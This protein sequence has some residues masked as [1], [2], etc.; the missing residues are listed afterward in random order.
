[1]VPATPTSTNFVVSNSDDSGPGSLREAIQLANATATASTITFDPGL[2]NQV[3]FLNSGELLITNPVRI[4]GLEGNQIIING[5]GE[6]RI[7]KIDSGGDNIDVL[8]ENLRIQEGGTDDDGGGIWNR[9]NLTLKNFEV[10]GNSATDD[11]GGIRNDGRLVVVDSVITG[12]RANGTSPTSGG[13]GILNTVGAS[14]TLINSTVSENTAPN[15]GG[16]RNDGETMIQNST[17]SGNNATAAAGGGG[18]IASSGNEVTIQNS[19][20]T[21]NRAAGVGAGISTAGNVMLTNS[22]VAANEDDKDVFRL[23]GGDFSSG[24]RNLIGNGD[25]SSF[26]DDSGDNIV[27]TS[28]GAIDPLLDSLNNNGGLTRTHALLD[29]SPAIDAGSSNQLPADSQDADGDSDTTEMIPFDQR[30][31]GFLRVFG[32]ALDIGA[33]EAVSEANEPPVAQSVMFSVVENSEEGTAVGGVSAFDREEAALNFAFADGNLDLDED[34]RSAFS[35]DASTGEITVNDVDDIDFDKLSEFDLQVKV[36]DSGDLSDTANVKVQVVEQ[37]FAQFDVE[38]SRNGVFVLGRGQLANLK[39]M[40]SEANIDSVGEVGFFLL[41]EDN[42]IDGLVA[43]DEGYELAALERSQV[44]FSTLANRPAG[45]S[46]ENIQRILPVD[47]ETRLG[48]LAVNDGTIEEA[49][50]D[51]QASGGNAFSILFSTLSGAQTSNMSATGFT[52]SIEEA[53]VTLDIDLTQAMPEKGTALQRESQQE[54]ID[55][56]DLT[57]SLAV[58]VD[59]YREAAFEN[60]IGFYKVSDRN[61]GIDI[62][63]DGNVD[64]NPGDEGYRQLALENRV[65]GLDLLATENQQMTT[66]DGVLDGGSLLAPFIVA[67]GTLEDAMNDVAEVYFSFVGANRD[68]TD[69]I[70]LL[71][72]NTFGFE[73]MVSGGDG[74]FNDMIVK[75]NFA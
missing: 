7:F 45:F 9:D 29:G 40:L 24:G 20:I 67:D 10:R 6:S 66:I 59:V 52:L 68:R 11:G 13:G 28:N 63:R 65:S 15:G 8:L 61:G 48:F 47:G 62:D 17:F 71:G 51:L 56:R 55:L 21:N 16:L 12:N 60:L 39:V 2:S 31:D 53:G 34:G 37:R 75:V 49:I 41:D 54:L 1:M 14:T 32:D 58:S 44:L 38:Q 43:A 74:D 3:I 73:D 70:R 25:N 30:G 46:L 22:I 35:I 27:G 18:A 69:H 23:F 72:D 5:D 42:K 33:Y 50:A 4:Q 26:A 36:T 57:E 64:V 19:T